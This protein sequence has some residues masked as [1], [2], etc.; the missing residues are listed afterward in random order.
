MA[1]KKRTGSTHSNEKGNTGNKRNLGFDSDKRIAGKRGSH[2]GKKSSELFSDKTALKEPKM[3]TEFQ[4][5]QL[6][7]NDKLEGRNS[8][9]E[10]LKANRTINKIFVIKGDREGSIRQIVAMARQKGIIITE[11][12][13]SALD[14]MSTSRS[15]QGVI[16][17]VAAKEYVEVD[18]ILQIAQDKGQ[19]P[20]II[21]LDEITDPHNFGAILRTANAVGAHGVIIPKR[22]AIGL[23]S[24]VSKASAGA[25][26]YVP[27]ARVTNISQTIEYLKKNNVWVVGTDATGEKAFYESDLKGPIAVVI[28]SEGEGMGKLIREKCDFVVNIPM[29]G[30]ISS[31]N[32]SVA[33]AIV[34]YEIL[35]QRRKS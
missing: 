25:V 21:I 16:A 15:H 9:L 13:K 1:G 33:A 17:L 31:L 11:V 7:D 8:V 22:R 27:V 4:E 19:P 30:E 29:E 28:G 23:T 18:D 26:E 14:S 6:E 20:F 2:T 24:A 35:K 12:E 34:M 3:H 5:E 32:A 10:A